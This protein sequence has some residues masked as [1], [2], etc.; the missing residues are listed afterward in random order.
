MAK[1]VIKKRVNLAFLGEEHKD[2]YLVFKSIPV[3]EYKDIVEQRP[4]DGGSQY[5]Y[6]LKI[7][8]NKFIEGKFQNETV[9]KEDL[10]EFDGETVTTCFARLTGQDT[11]PKV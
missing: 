1:I 9:N 8:Q 4:D 5:D 7:V 2:D 10:A 11:D 6:L 3:K